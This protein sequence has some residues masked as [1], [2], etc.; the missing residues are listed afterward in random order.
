MGVLHYE[1]SYVTWT[2]PHNPNDRRVPGHKSWGNSARILFDARC[3]LTED[4]TGKSEEFFLVVPCRT[5]WMYQERNMIQKPSGEYRA[6]HSRERYRSVGLGMTAPV[7]AARSIRAL[8]VFT[9]YEITVNECHGD[10][11]LTRTGRGG[12]PRWLACRLS[13]RTRYT[14]TALPPCSN[15]PSRR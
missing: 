13:P 2:I 12:Q 3:V 9:A 6:M 8:D 14:T 4:A 1:R 5:E 11:P 10:A 15:T 7:E